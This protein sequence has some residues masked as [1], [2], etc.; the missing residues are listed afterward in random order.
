MRNS[1]NILEVLSISL[2]SVLSAQAATVS[3]GSSTPSVG[4]G[5]QNLA[6]A[7]STAN[8][9]DV[10]FNPSNYLAGDNG[11]SL[12]QTFTTGANSGGYTLTSISVHQVGGFNTFWDFTGGAITLQVYQLGTGTGGVWN[13]TPLVTEVATVGG[14]PDGIGLSSGTQGSGAQWL[15]ITLTA[16]ATL[17]ANTQYGFQL[18]SDGTGGND[19]FFMELDG[20]N[21]NPYAGGFAT[22]TGKVAGQPN[23]SVVFDGNNGQPSDRAFVASMTSIPE[24]SSALL[25]AVGALALFRRRRN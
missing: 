7:T 10:Q 9:T 24:P 17:S 21:T 16:A 2:V 18:V 19:R 3:L 11:S 23:A 12:G 13:I 6:F 22:G 5:V 8:D 20:T 15:T 14:E 25:G 4:D 1:L